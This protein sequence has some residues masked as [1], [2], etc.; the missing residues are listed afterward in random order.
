MSAR[1]PQA[2]SDQEEVARVEV[3]PAREPDDGRVVVPRDRRERLARPDDMD[4]GHRALPVVSRRVVSGNR[5]AVRKGHRVALDECRERVRA[6]D[7]VGVHVKA[8]LHEA[9]A[10]ERRAVEVGV[11]GDADSLAEKQELEHRD[12]PAERPAVQRPRAEERA[13]ERAEGGARLRVRETG[14]GEPFAR[15]KARTAAT[16]RGPEIASIGP[17]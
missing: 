9:H 11:D 1:D 6:D 8:L 5:D 4:G 12:V 13:A 15:W 17:R 2:G 10:V 7:A 16:C 3:I 14:D